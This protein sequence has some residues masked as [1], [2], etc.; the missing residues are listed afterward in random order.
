MK[1]TTIV[2]FSDS[3]NL[4]LP[5]RLLSVAQ[6]NDYVLF[7]GDG[8]T[9]LGDLLLLKNLHAVKGNCDPHSFNDE[10]IVQIG[11]FKILLTHGD[12]YHVKRG[13]LELDLRARELGCT[14]VFYGHTHFASIDENAGI[15]FVCPGSTYSSLSGAPSYAYA[16]VHDG[17]FTVKIVNLT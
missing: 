14:L 16:V 5:P 1:M 7:L 3:H 12:K 8:I 6:E 10:E 13:L 2:A 15:T 4:P 17:K 9:S 11:D